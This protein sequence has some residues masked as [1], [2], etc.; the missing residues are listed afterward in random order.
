MIRNVL[1]TLSFLTFILSCG[2]KQD[3]SEILGT[4]I[5]KYSENEPLNIYGIADDL[6]YQTVFNFKIDSTVVVKSPKSEETWTLEYKV[7]QDT[8]IQY[9]VD[10][11]ALTADS[12][13]MVFIGKKDFMPGYRI[14]RQS[15]DSLILVSRYRK[16]MLELPEPN[17]FG[18]NTDMLKDYKIMLVRK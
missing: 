10:Y 18:T 6:P 11:E 14:K 16:A 7:I 12:T 17:Q 8:A 5:F 1:I 2:T 15:K 4:W 3:S 9:F 13:S